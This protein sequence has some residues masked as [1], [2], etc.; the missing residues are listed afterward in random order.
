MVPVTVLG[1][2]AINALE[3]E[4]DRSINHD[5]LY[6]EICCLPK[7]CAGGEIYHIHV[8]LIISSRRL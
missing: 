5:A 7:S 3:N 8:S 1:V 4:V 6:Q 2:T